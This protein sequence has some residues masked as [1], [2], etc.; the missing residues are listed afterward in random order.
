M[1]TACLFGFCAYRASFIRQEFQVTELVP[2]D[3]YVIPFLDAFDSYRARS[4]PTYAYFRF[5]DHAD[6]DM[7]HQMIEFVDELAA[8]DQFVEP[9]FCWVR[10]FQTLTQ[11][12]DLQMA[13]GLTLGNMSEPYCSRNL[14]QG[15]CVG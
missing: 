10:D 3:S 15:C 11:N 8:L 9:R 6:N 2:S 5:V 1:R 13:L 14:W 4:L 7:Q 12:A